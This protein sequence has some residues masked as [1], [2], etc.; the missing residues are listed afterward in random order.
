[1]QTVSRYLITN[2]VTATISGYNGRN[3]KV[4]DRRLRVYKGVSNPITFTFKNE[5]Q[6]AQF[7]TS[8]TYEF[9]L[10]DTESIKSVLTRNLTILDDG[11]TVATK[12]QASVTITDGDLLSLDA[13]F[14]NYAI[15][16][17]KSDNSREVTYADSFYNAS[18]SVEILSGAYPEFVASVE[19]TFVAMS[20]TT[21]RRT[22]G[23]IFARPGQ[24]NNSALHTVA[25]YW[26]GYTGNFQIQ[27]TL[28]STPTN[29][30]WY[31][32]QTVDFTNQTGITYY[33]FTGV[34]ENVRFT[35]DR[36]S[37]NTGSLD[38]LL[39]RL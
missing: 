13:K 24:N 29:T 8:K 33:N 21:T 19:P 30:D 26:T 2:L 22:S 23:N 7:I 16:E 27:G 35:H 28:A 6:K 17:V 37:G 20:G 5:D 15:R 34:W 11:S 18:G 39:Y 36:T 31:T 10:I 4:Y 12:G 38:K 14:Y 3:G 25:A 32:I 9:N 1:M